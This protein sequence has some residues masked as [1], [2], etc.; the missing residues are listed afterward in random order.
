ME[1]VALKSKRYVGS[2]GNVLNNTRITR[3]PELCGLDK[4][5]KSRLTRHW[6]CESAVGRIATRRQE[7]AGEIARARRV[8]EVKSSNF[9]TRELAREVHPARHPP[10]LRPSRVR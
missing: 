9:V 1:N 8:A 5:E 10:P 7:G 4:A 3:S 6:F 2:L